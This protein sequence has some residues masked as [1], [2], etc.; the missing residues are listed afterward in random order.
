MFVT[1][2]TFKA[3]PGNEEAV[4]DLFKE[5]QRELMPTSRG[6]LSSEVLRDASD[7]SHFVSIARFESE[8]ALRA[9][10]DRPAQDAWYRKLVALTEREPIFTD[11]VLE[12]STR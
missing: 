4:L 9:V 5:W 1:M 12:W 6:F 8:A 11:C 10:A 7:P 2:F 3:Q